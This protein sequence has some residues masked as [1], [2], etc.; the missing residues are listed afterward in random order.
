MQ[1]ITNN[2]NNFN[3]DGQEDYHAEEYASKRILQPKTTDKRHG[4]RK[5]HCQRKTNGTA[6]HSDQ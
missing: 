1:K 5:F 3:I 4:R 2:D 6:A